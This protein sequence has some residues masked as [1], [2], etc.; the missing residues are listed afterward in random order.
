[1]MENNKTA[2]DIFHKIMN[3]EPCERTLNWEFGY[4]VETVE[5]WY[6]KG[7][8]KKKGDACPDQTN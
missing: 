6:S 4:W 7:L 8:P 5:K 2:R 1:M 3:F